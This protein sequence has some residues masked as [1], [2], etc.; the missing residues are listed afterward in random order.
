MA[1][2]T[3]HPP[4]TRVFGKSHDGMEYVLPY[5]RDTQRAI[6]N[7]YMLPLT[8]SQGSPVSILGIMDS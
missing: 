8:I 1:S 3:L 4:Y 6:Y 5:P 2:E 7:S